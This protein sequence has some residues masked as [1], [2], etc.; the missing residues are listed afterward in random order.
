MIWHDSIHKAKL[1]HSRI[2]NSIVNTV[3]NLRD[4]LDASKDHTRLTAPLPFL[5]T[6]LRI[7]GGELTQV[8]LS[9][10]HPLRSPIGL[11]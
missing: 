1:D 10:S 11:E 9:P 7:P 3:I 2:T 5:V 8:P 4:S 6:K